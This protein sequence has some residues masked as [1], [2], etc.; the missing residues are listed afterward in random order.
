MLK[1]WFFQFIWRFFEGYS[2][3]FLCQGFIQNFLWR[4]LQ[5]CLRHFSEDHLNDFFHTLPERAPKK[6][7]WKFTEYWSKDSAKKS[8]RILPRIF[9][10]ISPRILLENFPKNLLFFKIFSL[11]TFAL[12]FFGYSSYNSCLRGVSKVSSRNSSYYFI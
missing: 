9:W 6:I 1:R 4:F 2:E 3:V 10:E 12:I 11:N 8:P 7:F 5:N